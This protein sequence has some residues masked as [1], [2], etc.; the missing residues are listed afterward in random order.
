MA[1]PGCPAVEQ[2]G[3]RRLELLCY[4]VERVAKARSHLPAKIPEHMPQGLG[5]AFDVAELAGQVVEPFGF[6][7][8][9]LDDVISDRS[10]P[11]QSLAEPSDV[12][13]GLLGCCRRVAGQQFGVVDFEVVENPIPDERD[14]VLGPGD[15]ERCLVEGAFGV[16]EGSGFPPFFLFGLVDACLDRLQLLV[17]RRNLGL[18]G[19]ELPDEVVKC[20]LKDLCSATSSS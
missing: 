14:A 7:P 18:R 6:F 17:D 12:L 3:E 16:A 5:R 1:Q 19:I 9:L 8:V 15:V 4:V 2:A 20:I 13:L 10:H 11:P